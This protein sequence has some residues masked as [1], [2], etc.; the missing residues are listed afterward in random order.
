[1]GFI[2]FSS[3]YWSRKEG[4]FCWQNKFF[5]WSSHKTANNAKHEGNSSTSHEKRKLTLNPTFDH[6]D[7]K[8]KLKHT[9]R[10][11]TL[12]TFTSTRRK[13]PENIKVGRNNIGDHFLDSR[14]STVHNLNVVAVVGNHVGDISNISSEKLPLRQPQDNNDKNAGNF[15]EIRRSYKKTLI[16]HYFEWNLKKL[17]TLSLSLADTTLIYRIC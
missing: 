2:C 13:I 15:T 7:D 6:P 4:R 1:M 16:Y 10:G 11:E 12:V 3:C 9:R 17:Y 8:S 14:R 5:V